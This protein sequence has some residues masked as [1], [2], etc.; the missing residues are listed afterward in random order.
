VA[1]EKV[2][3]AVV[4]CMTLDFAVVSHRL[5]LGSLAAWIVDGSLV[6]NRLAD[7]FAWASDLSNGAVG[8]CAG[9]LAEGVDA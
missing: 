9:V 3:V 2:A 5:A 1:N 6:R 7:G 8:P 4:V